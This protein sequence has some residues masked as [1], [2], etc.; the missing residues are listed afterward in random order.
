MSGRPLD[1]APGFYR[2]QL[3][4]GA[5]YVGVK[6]ESNNPARDEAGDLLEDEILTMTVNGRVTTDYDA[7][8]R[9]WTWLEPI[10]EAEYRYLIDTAAYERHHEPDG[11]FANPDKAVD[12]RKLPPIAP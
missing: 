7:I 8:E 12:L 11:P 6:I 3:A 9:R 2:T 4:K 10:D 5:V 1:P